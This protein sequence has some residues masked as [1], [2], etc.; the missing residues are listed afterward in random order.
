LCDHVEEEGENKVS[1]AECCTIGGLILV[2]GAE[3][4]EEEF[5]IFMK[6]VGSEKH[7]D[8]GTCLRPKLKV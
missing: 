6:S 2:A 1:Y 7:T 4:L 3:L 8:P 5:E